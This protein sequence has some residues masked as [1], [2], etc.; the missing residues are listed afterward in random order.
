MVDFDHVTG[1]LTFRSPRVVRLGTAKK[2][3]D[4][5][6]TVMKNIVEGEEKEDELPKA[7]SLCDPQRCSV[8]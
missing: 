6:K 3:V 1:L 7:P 5:D 8:E 4:Q 2:R